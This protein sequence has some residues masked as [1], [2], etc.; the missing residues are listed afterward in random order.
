MN[1]FDDETLRRIIEEELRA[2]LQERP[3]RRELAQSPQRPG[4]GL[5]V[6]CT[7]PWMDATAL[8]PQL[9]ELAS[10]FSLT[11]ILSA[12]FQEQKGEEELRQHVGTSGRILS[13]LTQETITQEVGAHP[14]LVVAPLSSNTLAKVALGVHDSVPSRVIFEALRQAKVVVAI[15]PPARPEGNGTPG[16]GYPRTPFEFHN[17]R[18]QYLRTVAN[19]G[20]RFV[21]SDRLLSEVRQAM[22]EDGMGSVRKRLFSD[23]RPKKRTV[24]TREDVQQIILEGKR[25]IQIS[26]NAIVTDVA[27]ELAASAG[28][29]IIVR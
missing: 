16:S 18:S 28:I 23:R 13:R 6:L 14:L 19:W 15:P 22:S 21:D 9:R 4:P 17:G 3:G 24:I 10:T 27:K 26:P 5:L 25:E 12:S 29:Q 2:C 8:M 20:I 7:G 11:F 1:T